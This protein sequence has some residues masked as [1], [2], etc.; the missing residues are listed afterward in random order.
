VLFSDALLAQLDAH[1]LAAVYAHEIAHARRH[2]V[3]IFVA[4]VLAFF[5]GGDLLAQALFPG[6]EWLAAA[7]LLASMGAWFLLFGWL[8]RRYELEADLFAIALLRDTG[9]MVSALERVGGSLRDVASWRHF[10]TARRVEFLERAAREPALARSFQARLRRWSIA[11]VLLFLVAGALEGRRLVQDYGGDRL[12][13]HLRLGEYAAAQERAAALPE[14]APELRALVARG[15][16]IGHA[17]R[18]A[19][20]LEALAR[21]AIAR[22]ELQAGVEFLQLGALRGRKELGL[23]AQA[24]VDRA[25]ALPPELARAWQAE[26]ARAAPQ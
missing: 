26:L 20:E 5:L 14:L 11:G 8:S 13:A 25:Q 12:R 16:S 10:S 1:E 22:G 6:S 18:D 9:A 24:L 2:H 3:P 19:G 23:V 21:A 7:L 15:S 4:W 17:P